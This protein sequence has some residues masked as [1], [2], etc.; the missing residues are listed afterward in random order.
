MKYYDIQYNEIVMKAIQLI[1]KRYNDY[2]MWQYI[3]YN[4]CEN[5]YDINNV[6]AS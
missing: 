5:G 2:L 4:D 6:K 1:M 3:V